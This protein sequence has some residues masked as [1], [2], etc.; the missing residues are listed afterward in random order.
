MTEAIPERLQQAI[1]EQN[2]CFLF[3]KRINRDLHENILKFPAQKIAYREHLE[4]AKP[5]LD[6]IRKLLD[7]KENEEGV[8]EGNYYDFPD[9]LLPDSSNRIRPPSALDGYIEEATRQYFVHTLN[10]THEKPVFE[11]SENQSFNFRLDDMLKESS[12]S[13]SMEI[14][15]TVDWA[16]IGKALAAKEIQ[17]LTSKRGPKKSAQMISRQVCLIEKDLNLL[18][19]LSLN[20]L[21]FK[22]I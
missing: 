12:L 6:E 14:K 1:K 21:N 10:I 9:E 11:F 20:S 2:Q 22:M 17:K 13:D 16:L 7:D 4:K 18:R 5:L 15:H 19:V 3:L 8:Y